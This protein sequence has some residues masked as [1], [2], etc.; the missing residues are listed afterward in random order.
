MSPTSV[1]PLA[2]FGS[3]TRAWFEASFEDATRVQRMGWPHLLAGEHA[4]LCAPTGSGK[5]LAAFLACLD[6]VT[7]TPP[8]PD[9]GVRVLYVSPLK[10]LAYDIERNLRAPLAG[11][12]LAGGAEK[13][14]P[15][16]TAIRTGDTPAR[17]RRLLGRDPSEI[18]VT[19]PESLYLLLG[20]EARRILT[21]VETV[22]IDE[23]HALAPT[24]R[25]AHL[26]LS[27]E[28]LT[29]LVTSNGHNDP[30]RVGLSATQRPLE[31]V[32]R[33]LGGAR[34]VT[35]IDAGEKPRLDLRVE[36]P[37]DDLEQPA[38][39]AETVPGR[40]R[41]GVELLAVDATSAEDRRGIWPA[42]HDRVLEL[43][44]EHRSTI[45]FTNSR[46]LCERLAQRLNEL[47]AERG[48]DEV[49]VRAHHGSIA[50][51]QRVEIE[52]LLKQG[53]LRG[54]VATSSLEL[55][56]DMG[57]VDL[58]IQIESPG[59]VSRGLQ[60]VG[61]AGHS[62]GAR[63]NARVLP[64]FRQDLLE[65]TVIAGRML[66]GDVEPIKVP[67]NPLD[68]LS[69]QIVA[70]TADR[71]RTVDEIEVIARGA[72]P[73]QTLSREL[74]VAVLDMLAGRYPADNLGDLRPRVIWDRAS[75]EVVARKDAKLIAIVNAGT[76]PDRGM[77]GVHLEGG[78]PRVGE[79]D[80]EMVHES[81]VGQTF[82]LGASSWRILEITRDRVIVRPAPGEPGRMPF[83]RGEGPGRPIELGR[84][85]GAFLREIEPEL[86]KKSARARL[87]KDF[88]LDARAA[89]NLCRYLEEQRAATTQL[90]TDRVLIVE[91][92]RDELGDWRVCLLSPFGARVHAPL[93][94]AL[95]AKLR[96]R[97]GA[98]AQALHSDDGI[99]LRVADSDAPPALSDLLPDPEEL[100]ELVLTE[101]RSSSLFATHF[102]ENAAR[103]LLLPRRRPGKRTPLWTQR[104]K[105]QNLLEVA[106][107]FPGFP[108]VLETFREC[109]NDIFDVPA[110]V[111]LLGALRSRHVRL[112]EVETPRPS[113]FAK[114]LAFAYVAAYLYEGD[115]PLA[116]RKA[117]ALTLDRDLLRELLGEVEARSL[118]DATAIAEVE[119]EL[120]STATDRHVRSADG[121][122]DLLRR[123][124]DLPQREIAAR[125]DG[126]V[127]PM[128]ETLQRTNRAIQLRLGTPVEARWVAI[129]DVARYRDALGAPLPPGVP[130]VYLEP[131][132]NAL[133]GLLDRYART[134]GPFTMA[135]L[136]AR[137]ALTPSQLSPSVRLAVLTGRWL[138][139]AFRPDGTPGAAAVELCDP[140]VL[141]RLR[142]QTLA[143]LRSEIAPVDPTVLARF[144][145][146]WHGITETTRRTRGIERLREALFALEG[147]AVPF[148]ELED[149]LLPSRVPDYQP[150]LLDELGA[151]G[152]IVWLGRGAI[153][154]DDG[155]VAIYFRDHI[156]KL[157]DIP[158]PWEG[159]ALHALV[160][161]Q[162]AQR[163]AAF[164]AQ[165]Q[166]A[167]PTTLTSE[168]EAAVWDL[169]WSGQITNDTFAPLRALS[170]PREHAKVVARRPGLPRPT[171]TLQGRWSL[172]SA[173]YPVA[174]D[175]TSAA[176][177]RALMLLERY[178][179]V[180]REAAAAEEIRG[181]FGAVAGVLRAMEE[182]GRVRRGYF[183]EGLAGAQYALPGA[184]DR[185]RAAR[186]DE[187][188]QAIVLSAIDPANPFGEF[189]AW[190]EVEAVAGESPGKPR[191]SAG[192]IVVLCGA[193]PVLFLERGGKKLLIFKRSADAADPLPRAIAALQVALRRPTG[194][195][196]PRFV[197]V[198]EVNGRPALRSTFAGELE[199][200]GLR[201][202]PG[203]LILDVS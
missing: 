171:P 49:L 151:A 102:R 56:I 112:V 28:R 104:L 101:L 135:E 70:M 177:A 26:A 5:T 189:L 19:T 184:L 203:G 14:F 53:Q 179:V 25:G 143:K 99:V 11:I 33:F 199:R 15:V 78:G 82:L 139:G 121:V 113:P 39:M 103:A 59:S 10:A 145:P 157:V 142:R 31:E 97:T 180:M 181:G 94:L 168:L 4:L 160:L 185:L 84:A 178:G 67:R 193:R 71:S 197:R 110:L 146:S 200:A 96:E 196:R 47:W 86:G 164:F 91:R 74:L 75:D 183:V 3:A 116:E 107:K 46:R 66:E 68:V 16:R 93:A 29:A 147:L 153:G 88:H 55:G 61:R 50:R 163:G 117:Q 58:V 154:S 62:I 190:P 40:P 169:V 81:R 105:A 41:L 8:A 6:T 158:A 98:D 148:S 114:S 162:L 159:E 118:L 170:Q 109:Y 27:L 201:V 72:Y 38:P 192:A 2:G 30:Q 186:I 195:T 65:A 32:A 13:L 69:Q 45:V 137:F 188:E 175:P 89:E 20:S 1:S 43:V 136:V 51:E 131:S 73:Y 119:A 23:I 202:E 130:K 92:F 36:V 124:G 17:E 120:Q 7:R 77:Y 133:D 127:A 83:W 52:E 79:L 60:R 9:G 64:K 125:C 132:V 173:L 48:H 198:A 35:I 187:D 115:S 155:K 144:L 108:I 90:P 95:E 161:E 106:S 141:R 165:L 149:K 24:K 57:A 152:E 85:M 111:E 129:E 12:A 128:L 194:T 167:A 21:G 100:E 22:I 44:A 166:Q 37:V 176:H 42:L 156:A 63:S 191:R 172:A 87:Q 54:I 134:H 150:R 123:L 126:E 18:L 140:E 138:E 122:H 80:E 182:A 76:I 34:P 174:A